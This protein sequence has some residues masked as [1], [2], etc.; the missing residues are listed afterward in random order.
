MWRTISGVGMHIMVS[1]AKSISR[2]QQSFHSIYSLLPVIPTFSMRSKQCSAVNI[3]RSYAC[4][5]N[6]IAPGFPLQIS[7]VTTPFHLP[8]LNRSYNHL[9]CSSVGREI[10]SPITYRHPV[11]SSATI[12]LVQCGQTSHPFSVGPSASKVSMCPHAVHCQVL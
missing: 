7:N 11:S 3:S 12:R 8:R 10:S 1:S 6:S 2:P 5:T 4:I 9:Y